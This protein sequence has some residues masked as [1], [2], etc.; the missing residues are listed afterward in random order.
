M[1]VRYGLATQQ[2][3]R[4]RVYISQTEGGCWVDPRRTQHTTSELKLTRHSALYSPDVKLIINNTH[5]VCTS[6][7]WDFLYTRPV[8]SLGLVSP[9]AVTDG[10]TLFFRHKNWRLFSHHP[11]SKGGDLFIVIFIAPTFQLT[12]SPF[13]KFNRKKVWLTSG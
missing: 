4:R 3:L 12:V 11:L 10:V 7:A 5:D 13:V 2:M 9:R 6:E 8:A 1:C